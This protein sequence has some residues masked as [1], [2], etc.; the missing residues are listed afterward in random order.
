MIL[1]ILLVLLVFSVLVIAHEFGHFIVAKRNGIKVYEFGVGFPP[2]LW[3]KKWRG[4]EYTVN[5]LP[6]GGFVRLEGEDNESK[7]PKSFASKSLWVKTNSTN[8]IIKIITS[9]IADI[10]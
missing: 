3:G 5:L 9:I 7:G 1:I 10:F 8:R 6:L 4:T 2:K